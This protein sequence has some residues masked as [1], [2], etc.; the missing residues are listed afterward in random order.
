[1]TIREKQ[2][3][4][5][6][7][8]LFH[9]GTPDRDAGDGDPSFVIGWENVPSPLISRLFARI[10][11]AVERRQPKRFLRSPAWKPMTGAPALGR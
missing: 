3:G 2:L 9:K 8:Y 5:E 11:A 4:R 7:T 10:R 1:M 6:P